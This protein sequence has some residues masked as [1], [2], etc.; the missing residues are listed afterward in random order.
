VLAEP[1]RGEAALAALDLDAVFTSDLTR[2]AAAHIRA[3]ASDPTAGIPADDRE[4]AAQ[5]AELAVRAT[6]AR[7]TEAALEAQSLTLELLRVER[8]ITAARRAGSGA[9]APLV[10]RR[11]ELRLLRDRAIERTLQETATSETV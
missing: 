4:L 5:V 11:E 8:E 9:V 3:H 2:R 6:A 7:P 1:G 10:A